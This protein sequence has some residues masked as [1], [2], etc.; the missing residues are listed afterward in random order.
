MPSFASM[1]ERVLPL[2]PDEERARL[3]EYLLADCGHGTDA[4]GLDPSGLKLAYALGWWVHENWFQ[5]RSEGHQHIPAR[6]AAVVVANHSG[7]LPYDAMMIAT[8]VFRNTRPP[9]LVRYMVDFFVYRFPFLGTFFRSVG[10]IPGTRANFDGLV[11]EGHVV[12]IFPEGADA[13]GKPHEQAYQLYPFTHGHAEL[14]A[15]H[16][17]PVIPAGVVGAEEQMRVVAD[18]KPLARALRLP[19]VP[20]TTTLIFPKPVQYF[21]CYGEPIHIDPAA[22]ESIELRTREVRRVREAVEAQIKRGLEPPR[23]VGVPQ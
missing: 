23:A 20:V 11:D 3:D 6:G 4:F 5:V 1:L 8:D 9:R 13:L 7:V 12:G 2:L 19:S 14:A 18:I 15:R 16:G 10:Q 17:A 22:L 21:I